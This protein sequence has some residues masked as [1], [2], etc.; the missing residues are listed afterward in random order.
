MR[1]VPCKRRALARATQVVVSASGQ[2][3]R[4]AAEWLAL[5]HKKGTVFPYS[6][7][8]MLKRIGSPHGIPEAPSLTRQI[9]SDLQTG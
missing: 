3:E 1:R 6:Q 2:V 9:P 7:F 4:C 5:C 8:A